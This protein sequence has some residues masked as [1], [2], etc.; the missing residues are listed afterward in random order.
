DIDD[1]LILYRITASSISNDQNE[2]AITATVAN[3]TV[4]KT[5]KVFKIHLEKHHLE[6]RTLTSLVVPFSSISQIDKSVLLATA[7]HKHPSEIV[8][9]VIQQPAHGSLILESLRGIR[10]SKFPT[11]HC[12][13][14]A[15]STTTV[16]FSFDHCC[17]P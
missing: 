7:S 5:F 10:S 3:L 15:R 4:T 17:I 14:N 16:S 13:A 11:L 8:F 1:G 9:D 2:Q 6:M 12:Y